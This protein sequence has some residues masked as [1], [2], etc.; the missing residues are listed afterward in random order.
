MIKKCRQLITATSC[1]LASTAAFC[2]DSDTGQYPW[3]KALHKIAV[4]LSSNV[5]VGAGI[6]AIVICGLTMAFVDLQGGGKKFI[7]IA[8]GLSICFAAT[9][10]ITKFFGHGAI[11]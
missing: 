11:I 6:I 5:A 7:Q 2:S 1:L 8:L 10:L 3:D 9:S 4:D